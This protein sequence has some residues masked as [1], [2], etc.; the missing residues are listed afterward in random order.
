MNYGYIRTGSGD[1][2]TLSKE[3]SAF[4]VAEIY[5][6]G[7]SAEE[8]PPQLAALLE[9]LEPRDVVI[10]HACTSLSKDESVLQKIIARIRKKK[11]AVRFLDLSDHGMENPAL[12]ALRAKQTQRWC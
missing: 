9:K 5:S 6:D 10:T 3:L 11:A 8:I 12:R 2:D 4:D 1:Y 7:D